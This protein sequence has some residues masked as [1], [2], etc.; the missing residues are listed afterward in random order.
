MTKLDIDT[1]GPL[2]KD[3]HGYQFIIVMIDAFSRYINLI[4]AKDTSA[5]AAAK[6]L[7]IHSCRFGF[8]HT[9]TTDNGSQFMNEMFEHLTREFGVNHIR[10]IPYSKEENGIVE[11]ANKEVNRHIR[12]ITFD[13]NITDEWSDYLP[14][15]ERLFNSAI[16][17]PL[18]VSPNTII[19]GNIIDTDTGFIHHIHDDQPNIK[20]TSMQ[21]YIDKLL[22]QQQKIINASLQ[23][24]EAYTKQRQ[25][26]NS[27]QKRHRQARQKLKQVSTKEL[28]EHVRHLNIDT[29]KYQP[30]NTDHPSKLSVLNNIIAYDKNL[31]SYHA[32]NLPTKRQ[33]TS[34]SST[35]TNTLQLPTFISHLGMDYTTLRK[36]TTRSYTPSR[37]WILDPRHITIDSDQDRPGIWIP[38]STIPP[39]HLDILKNMKE[40]FKTN[41]LTRHKVGDYVLRRHPSTKAGSGPPN[42]Y[43]SFWRGPY[44]IISHDEDTQYNIQNLVTG[45]ISEAHVQHLKP[46]YYDPK[47]VEPLNI[48]AKDNNEFIVG[49]IIQHNS[50]PQ[51]GIML[52]RVRWHGYDESEDTWEPFETLCD[53]E[54]FH[55]YCL[56]YPSLHRYL[57]SSI[58]KTLSKHKKKKR[59]SSEDA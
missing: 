3:Q 48:A 39:D 33:R 56:R 55:N 16:K 14:M 38:K 41:S 34:C 24:Q 47:H 5:K 7:Y 31:E 59:S 6:A 40:Y 28:D 53:V 4:P 13:K 57:P 30:S 32:S 27:Q 49:D 10:T 52:W 15:V 35:S 25:M 19:Y 11:R 22:Q 8:P 20:P 51:T 42:K 45:V 44:L 1:I 29:H 54:K 36:H 50:D 18:G 46:F 23:H 17:D 37:Q 58:K 43:G 26:D 2:P 12:N 21:Q 9:I